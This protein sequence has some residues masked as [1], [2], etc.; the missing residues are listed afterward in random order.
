MLMTY[1]KTLSLAA[2]ILLSAEVA[3]WFF[4][5]LPPQTIEQSSGYAT[6]Y[7]CSINFGVVWCLTDNLFNWIGRGEHLTA[8]STAIIAAFT[9]IL[10]Y[11]A[12]RSDKTI[13]RQ[14]E[15]Q[16]RQHFLT[17]RP[18]LVVRN[19]RAITDVGEPIKIEFEVINIGT[20][21]AKIIASTFDI[22]RTTKITAYDSDPA[23]IVGEPPAKFMGDIL[24]KVNAVWR[25]CPFT[26]R[27]KWTEDDFHD[28]KI[29]NKGFFFMGKILYRDSNGENRRLGIFR[30][31]DPATRRFRPLAHPDTDYEYDD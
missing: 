19:V 24:L 26:H 5:R 14:I 7:D 22:R 15:L 20:S 23:P 12:S 6:Y 1:R 9:I 10:A 28:D 16:T 17:H 21:D 27:A 30:R 18:H 13:Q 4:S 11:I 31:L 3:S 8:I 29:P 25:D 2:L